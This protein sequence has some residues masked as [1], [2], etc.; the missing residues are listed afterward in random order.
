MPETLIIPYRSWCWCLKLCRWRLCYMTYGALL[1]CGT[2]NSNAALCLRAQSPENDCGELTKDGSLSSLEGNHLL[3][4]RVSEQP[5]PAPPET[6][7]TGP[8]PTNRHTVTRQLYIAA[9]LPLCLSVSLS[10]CRPHQITARRPRWRWHWITCPGRRR[11]WP[12]AELTVA[13]P[14]VRWQQR[15]RS[16]RRPAGT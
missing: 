3:H 10:L 6:P 9:S 1:S 7:L 16:G 12:P 5:R 13:T 15:R 11:L 8:G 4:R 14:G 2:E